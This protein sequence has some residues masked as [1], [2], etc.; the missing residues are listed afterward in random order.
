M[1]LENIYPSIFCTC[2]IH[3]MGHRDLLPVNHKYFTIYSMSTEPKAGCLARWRCCESQRGL[4][5]RSWKRGLRVCRQILLTWVPAGH[6]DVKGRGVRAGEF[7]KCFSGTCASCQTN[8]SFCWCRSRS[9]VCYGSYLPGKMRSALSPCYCVWHV[10][11]SSASGRN[12]RQS[13][14]GRPLLRGF[15]NLHGLNHYFSQPGL[16]GAVVYR[17]RAAVCGGEARLVH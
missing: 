17:E 10:R 2:F 7:P 1:L 11:P 12:F 6:N 3:T 14:F 13:E 9:P 16:V 4:E 8:A 15:S 5:L